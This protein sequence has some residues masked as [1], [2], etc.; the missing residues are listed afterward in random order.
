MAS[1]GEFR[2][3]IRDVKMQKRSHHVIENKGSGS[4]SFAKTNPL[5]RL[6][7]WLAGLIAE[8]AGGALSKGAQRLL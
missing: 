4:G 3:K 2:Q 8:Q 7:G 5:F 1:W 6:S